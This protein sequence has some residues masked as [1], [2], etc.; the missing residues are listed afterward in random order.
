MKFE[1]LRA[2]RF[3]TRGTDRPPL[4]GAGRS[5]VAA[6]PPSAES[7]PELWPATASRAAPQLSASRR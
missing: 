2:T 1:A 3:G 7:S 6:P 5:A 4:R